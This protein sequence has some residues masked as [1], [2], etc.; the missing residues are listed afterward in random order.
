MSSIMVLPLENISGNSAEEYFAD[1]MTDALIGDLA[2]IKGLHVISRTSSM[3]YKGT[4]KSLPGHRARDKRRRNRRRHCTKSPATASS[5]VRSLS[6]RRPDRH[7]GLGDYTRDVRDV[8]DLQSENSTSSRAGSAYS[9]DSRTS[10]RV[11]RRA[12]L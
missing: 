5:F 8:L 7:S 2:K 6:T 4:K 1:G 9:D 3:H 10:R 11:S 12:V